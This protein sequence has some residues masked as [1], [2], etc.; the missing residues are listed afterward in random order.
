MSRVR[1]WVCLISAVW[2][3]WGEDM[4]SK[5]LPISLLVVSGIVGL[6]LVGHL[7]L[8]SYA[9]PDDLVGQ[10]EDQ[11][12]VIKT[13]RREQFD[14]RKEIKDLREQNSEFA[15]KVKGDHKAEYNYLKKLRGS[16]GLEEEAGSG[17]IINL[18]DSPEAV[19][20]ELEPY[21]N[22]LV[23]ASDL[24]DVV[25]RLWAGGASAIAVNGKRVV[26]KSPITC[27]GNS[28]LVNDTHMLPPF[29]IVAL[30]DEVIL[31]QEM[32][33][34]RYL[35]DLAE[36]IR[37]NNLVFSLKRAEDLKV[38][39]YDGSLSTNYLEKKER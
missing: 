28:I 25:Q 36:R 13:L 22:L 11:K 38:G 4:R 8:P 34:E 39:V 16:L 35:P 33:L 23:H 14:L 18:G 5:P 2:L 27:V 19:R 21:D 1:S 31:M 30:G 12:E 26:A 3:D 9:R 7:R 37:N 15:E 17:I 20:A 10:V 29:E 6:M 24:R 32:N